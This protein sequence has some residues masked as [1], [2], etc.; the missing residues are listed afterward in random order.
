MRRWRPRRVR[1]P[2]GGTCR[3][4]P[5]IVR[6]S[7]D[8]DREGRSRPPPG[9]W[10]RRA[11]GRRHPSG[12]LDPR[13][14]LVRTA[15]GLAVLGAGFADFTDHGLVARVARVGTVDHPTTPGPCT[16]PLGLSPPPSVPFTRRWNSPSSRAKTVAAHPCRI[17]LGN[18][19]AA[20]FDH[21]LHRTDTA[22][23]PSREA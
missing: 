1:S 23:R 16:S 3:T 21:T 18:H 17:G 20:Q 22:A 5:R 11:V 13:P 4:S 12:L 6:R 14:T 9:L 15:L 2:S 10:R 8:A 7:G 19:A